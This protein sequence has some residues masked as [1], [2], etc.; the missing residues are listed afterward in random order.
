MRSRANSR[1]ISRRKRQ[2]PVADRR[3]ERGGDNDNRFTGII[4]QPSTTTN[5]VISVG[6]RGCA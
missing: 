1:S 2:R 5:V 6:Q 4:N 3:T